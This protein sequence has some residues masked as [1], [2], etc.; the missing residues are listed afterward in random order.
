MEQHGDLLGLQIHFDVDFQQVRI[1]TPS[2][3][4]FKTPERFPDKDFTVRNFNHVAP[5]STPKMHPGRNQVLALLAYVC[6]AILRTKLVQD[7]GVVE[8]V[9]VVA[10]QLVQL[11]DCF[12]PLAVHVAFHAVDIDFALSKCLEHGRKPKVVDKVGHRH[13]F[14][15]GGKV[16]VGRMAHDFP[17]DN[18]FFPCQKKIACN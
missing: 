10:Q 4:D 12:H 5:V 1:D 14:H 6:Q 16:G 9:L 11:F 15:V 2:V 18:T 3:I 8:R 17:H 7:D 13:G